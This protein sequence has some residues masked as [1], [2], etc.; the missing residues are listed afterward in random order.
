MVAKM[1]K[2]S[3]RAG[4]E[5][6]YFSKKLF[7]GFRSIIQKDHHLFSQILLDFKKMSKCSYPMALGS[8]FVFVRAFSARFMGFPG[9]CSKYTGILG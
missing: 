1:P 2:S 8:R 5:I 6:L 3:R 9:I 4:P 7:P